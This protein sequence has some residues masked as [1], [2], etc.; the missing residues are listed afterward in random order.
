LDYSD[1]TVVVPARDEKAVFQVVRGI[2]ASLNGCRVIVMYH[3]YGGKALRFSNSR[4][5]AYP[6]PPGKGRVI[7]EVQRK[8]L[9]KT[10]ILCFIDG[11]A[12]YEPKNLRKMI[13]MVREGYDMVLGNRLDGITLESMP[14]SIQF[15]NKVITV[16][17]N[18]LYG[19]RF[20]DSQTGLRAIRTSAFQSIDL[21]ETQFGIETEMNI[22]MRRMG[23]RL[24][25]ARADYYPRVGETKQ[26]KMVGGIKHIFIELRFLFYRPE[27]KE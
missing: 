2:L 9:V 25:E 26:M 8:R 13:A 24:G 11:D 21:E 14:K 12:T 18:L 16:V 19:L 7:M 20:R 5:K 6:A 15:G 4:V 10:P 27:R 3:G 23:L 17:A 1:A 22:K